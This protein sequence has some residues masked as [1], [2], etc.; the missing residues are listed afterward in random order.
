MVACWPNDR[1]SYLIASLEQWFSFTY[2][3][4]YFRLLHLLY[5]K[6]IGNPGSFAMNGIF[7]K[8]LRNKLLLYC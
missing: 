4:N 7:I 5:L 3:H 1:T 6:S 8:F 2:Q